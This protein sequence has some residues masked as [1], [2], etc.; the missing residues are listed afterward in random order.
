MLLSSYVMVWINL[1][2]IFMSFSDYQFVFTHIEN[3]AKI[4]RNK[5][6]KIEKGQVQVQRDRVEGRA[7]YASNM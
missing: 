1:S 3:Q 4:N 7:D 6:K 5:S 2:L